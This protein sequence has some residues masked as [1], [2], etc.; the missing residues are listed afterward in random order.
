MSIGNEPGVA[1]RGS[2][3]ARS[4]ARRGLPSWAPR[5][6]TPDAAAAAAVAA[7]LHDLG[8][9]GWTSLPGLRGPGRGAGRIDHVV[10][11]PGGVV[12]VD[13]TDAAQAAGWVTSLLAPRHRSAVRA[14]VCAT[15]RPAAAVEGC[16]AAVVSRDAL[17]D[18][19]RGLPARL[20]PADVAGLAQHLHVLLGE[21]WEPDVLTTAT[22]G[23]AQRA[24]RRRVVRPLTSD[25]A[26]PLPPGRGA[27]PTVDDRDLVRHTRVAL[28]LRAGV[29]VSV[30]W[31]AWVFTTA[32]LGSL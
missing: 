3:A 16:G 5:R 7:V 10:I 2:A 24:A 27:T 21:A 14:V 22:L 26:V 15:D 12:V 9:E 18:H 1:R 6:G 8:P 13:A 19:L 23:T 25:V 4:G 20:H 30:A 28:A 32:P 11:G 29:V 17:A 31:L